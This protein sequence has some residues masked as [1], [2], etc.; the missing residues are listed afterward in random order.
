MQPEQKTN[1]EMTA[2]AAP[3]VTPTTPEVVTE[4]VTETV[5]ETMTTEPMV[6]ESGVAEVGKKRNGLIAAAVII[7]LC[8]IAAGA[9]LFYNKSSDAVTVKEYPEVVAVVNGEEVPRDDFL[10]SYEQANG[11]AMQ[12]G[13]DPTLDPAIMAEVE[14]QAL[15]IAVNT[16]LMLQ[17][18]EKAGITVSDE[19][20]D[21]EVAKLEEQFGGAEQLAAALAGVGLD[22]AGMREDLREQLVVD[23]Y[24][25]NS[26]EWTTIEVTDEDVRAY[27]DEV[28][29]QVADVPAFEDVVDQ[30]R[31][32]L[33]Y[34]AQQEATTALIA[35]VREDAEI[36]TY[37]E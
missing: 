1:E 28:A 20:V 24:I 6:T 29:A 7:V 27:Y 35:R 3:E 34:Q 14:K 13:I 18:A 33:E 32:Q 37:I 15:D 4:T 17:E 25:T 9:F 16:V 10:Q 30:V 21:E 36:E 22:D 12:Q 11:I 23:Q 26:L 31:A 8:A 2:G 19:R 5:E